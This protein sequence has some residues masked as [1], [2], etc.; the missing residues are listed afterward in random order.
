MAPDFGWNSANVEEKP[1]PRPQTNDMVG[2]EVLMI[3]IS[4]IKLLQ[5][6]YIRKYWMSIIWSSELESLSEENIKKICIIIS[7]NG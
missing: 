6:T 3:F 2:D 1:T 7:R 5:Q 4:S